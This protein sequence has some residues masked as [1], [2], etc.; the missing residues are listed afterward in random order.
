[1]LLSGVR[2]T[3]SIVSAQL[4]FFAA[5]DSTEL[6]CTVY[7]ARTTNALSICWVQLERW[8]PMDV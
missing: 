3:F 5:N 1:M 2:N 4:S 8:S 6:V 7:F